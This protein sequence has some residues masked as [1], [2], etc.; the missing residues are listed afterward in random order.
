MRIPRFHNVL[1][2]QW[3]R[4]PTSC[5]KICSQAMVIVKKSDSWRVEFSF[6]GWAGLKSDTCPRFRGGGCICKRTQWSICLHFVTAMRAWAEARPLLWC[7]WRQGHCTSVPLNEFLPLDEFLP[8]DC[9][10]SLAAGASA[11]AWLVDNDKI[12]SDCNVR[13]ASCCGIHTDTT[14]IALLTMVR[15]VIL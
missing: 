13:N 6:V 14:T 7:Y 10:W 1:D 11:A 3:T 9:D 15:E 5:L 8:Q 12:H 4:Q 2:K